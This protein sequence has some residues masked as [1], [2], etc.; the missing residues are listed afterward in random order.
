TVSRSGETCRPQ[1]SASSPVFTTTVR[2]RRSITRPSPRSSLAPPVPPASAVIFMPRWSP[3][4]FAAGEGGARA[5]ATGGAPQRG[6]A[7]PAEEA[8]S[9]AA[10]ERAWQLRFRNGDEAAADPDPVE[11]L[12]SR[13]D[14]LD[15]ARGGEGERLGGQVGGHAQHVLGGRAGRGYPHRTVEHRGAARALHQEGSHEPLLFPGAPPGVNVGRGGGR[16]AG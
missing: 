14:G 12:R 9:G 5:A 11:A 8:E 3:S 13:E 6:A 1:I 10:A 2:S 7:P 4:V 16:C 15:A